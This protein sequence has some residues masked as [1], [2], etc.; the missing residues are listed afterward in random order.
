[1]TLNDINIPHHDLVVEKHG[2]AS[3]IYDSCRKENG[4]LCFYQDDRLVDRISLG[5]QARFLIGSRLYICQPLHQ[6][7]TLIF[8]NLISIIDCQ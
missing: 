1:M 4:Y 3:I 2:R 5:Y 8:C 6:D 7:R